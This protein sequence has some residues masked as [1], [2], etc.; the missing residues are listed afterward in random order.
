MNDIRKIPIGYYFVG[1]ER[2]GEVTFRGVNYYVEE[3]INY[4]TS[5]KDAIAKAESK[6]AI[7]I[8]ELN[9]YSSFDY[10][11]ILVVEGEYEIDAISI[12]KSLYLIGDN[13]FLKGSFWY[14]TIEPKDDCDSFIIDSFSFENIRLNDS[15]SVEGDYYLTFK[16]IKYI[17]AHP[18]ISYFIDPGSKKSRVHLSLE[19]IIVDG[20]DGYYYGNEF[21]RISVASLLINN[22]T[23]KNTDKLF[24]FSSFDR[25]F[26]NTFTDVD[27]KYQI[28]NAVFKNNFWQ[29]GIT[30]NSEGYSCI[31]FNKSS[32]ENCLLD[33][34]ISLF[35]IKLNDKDL[36]TFADCDIK[37]TGS[38][39]F[40]S[41][42]IK[43]N[44]IKIKNTCIA[45]FDKDEND[46]FVF[47][48]AK[49]LD[50]FVLSQLELISDKHELITNADFKVLEEY[51]DNRKP[52]YCDMHV[53]SNS[54]G[55]SDG[56]VN[57]KDWPKEMNEMNLDFVAIAD[58]RQMRHFF[59]NEFDD[60]KFF[61]CTEPAAILKG[62]M[63]YNEL[64][65]NMIFPDK[66]GL[67]KVL[68]KYDD[69]YHFKGDELTGYFD[70][71]EFSH[72]DL[73][74]V[75]SFISSIGGMFVHAHPK[76]MLVSDNIL[77]YFFG[78]HTYIEAF[79]NDYSSLLSY[80]DYKLWVKLL[81]LGKK[82]YNISGSDSHSHCKNSC[83]N[84]VY[85]EE[86]MNSSLFKYF[87]KGDFSSGA[88]G[89][90]M[91]IGSTSMGGTTKYKKNQKLLIEI[92]DLFNFYRNSNKNF[93]VKVISS[94]G[95]IYSTIYNGKE[96]LR[97]AFETKERKFYRVEIIDLDCMLPFGLSNP[98]WLD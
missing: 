47:N 63:K 24:G 39:I 33:E 8:D 4:F 6:P 27:T 13:A 54:G 91:L 17:G 61:Y 79:S 98:I 44:Q 43:P 96:K 11:V 71:C 87:K 59:L 7:V 2:I 89:I 58:H 64:H 31:S 18:W 9:D 86:K 3:G 22:L 16:N 32:F 28:N 5:F 92:D 65:Y 66:Y 84:V 37:D 74:K 20:I 68:K 70:Y 67:K 53:H 30:L 48:E 55:T 40:L 73:E 82:V 78:D 45:G 62:N 52:F 23:Y 72:Q 75:A 90:K 34:T 26:K 46:S 95:T 69:L 49:I 93:I 97:L 41:G 35:D 81:S 42:N 94:E 56:Q 60:T 38:K 15:R 10:P 85:A 57:I 83:I 80:N 88:F 77:D 51:Y 36:L 19:N 50:S 12:N 1:K 25:N 21:M 29:K 14:G 76:A